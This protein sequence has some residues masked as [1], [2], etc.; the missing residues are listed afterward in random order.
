LVEA[1]AKMK[2]NDASGKSLL[3]LAC[4]NNFTNAEIIEYL[5]EEGCDPFTLD[6][7]QGNGTCVQKILFPSV[8]KPDIVRATGKLISK[9]TEISPEDTR[10]FLNLSTN[11]LDPPIGMM[12]SKWKDTK[13]EVEIVKLLI[14]A[15]ANSQLRFGYESKYSIMYHKKAK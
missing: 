2:I 4:D 12:A 6:T 13:E 3:S 7:N 11:R 8:Y 15:G 10:K 5:L 9:M 1:G 14:N